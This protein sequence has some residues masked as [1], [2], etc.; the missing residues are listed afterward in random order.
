MYLPARVRHVSTLLSVRRG[1]VK[2]LE[3]ERKREKEKEREAECTGGEIVDCEADGSCGVQ[4]RIPREPRCVRIRSCRISRAHCEKK[5][6]KD[7]ES[8]RERERRE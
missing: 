5:E 3:I 2:H 8:Y 7:A 4:C 6:R 1:L